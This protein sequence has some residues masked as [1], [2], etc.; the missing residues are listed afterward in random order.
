MNRIGI[1]LTSVLL[2]ASVAS[3]GAAAECPTPETVQGFAT[4]ADVKKATAEGK[5]VVYS[6]DVEQGTVK[7]LRAFETA[8]PAIKTQYVRLQTGALYS[9][10]LAERQA[11]SHL[12]DVVNLSD[13][14][15]AMDFQKRSGYAQYRSPQLAAFEPRFKSKPEGYYTW[16][17]VIMGGIAYNPNTI[18]GADIPKDWPDL[19]QSKWSGA[20]SVKS[21]NSGL[22]YA[23]WH[24]LKETLGD[25]YWKDFAALRP[26]AFDS[27]V[28][29]FDRL[30]NGE[31]KFAHTAQ[32]SG[33]LEFQQKGAPLA[34]V[35]PASGLPTSPEVW[36]VIKEAPNPQAARLF[37]DWFLSPVG[38]RAMADALFM[39][40]ARIDVDPPAKGIPLKDMKLLVPDDWDNYLQGRKAFIQEWGRMSGLR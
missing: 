7:L 30:V 22:Q 35:A 23:T 15:L 13:I 8:F 31:D 32:Y 20:V 14:G 24:Q 6:P 16:G 39:H 17:A 28:Q 38:Q 21:A 9:K 5:L 29:Q 36:G 33:V 1:T 11:G 27:Y 3:A 4:C 19:N 34:F 25:Q 37:I 10:L 26:R 40:S 2:T 18:K 12:V